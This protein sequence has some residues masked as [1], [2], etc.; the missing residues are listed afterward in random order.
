[1]EFFSLSTSTLVLR[2]KLRLPGLHTSLLSHLSYPEL[3]LWVSAYLL[4]PRTEPRTSCV[5][6][7]NSNSEL[8]HLVAIFK[9]KI[10]FYLAVCGVC[11]FYGTHEAI[12]GQLG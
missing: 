1:M 12:M 5:L 3:I 8:Y 9:K 6:I 4:S 10:F 11:V 2:I 7:K